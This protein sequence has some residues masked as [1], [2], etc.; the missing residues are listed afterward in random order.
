MKKP[1][2]AESFLE[3]DLEE[4]P[5]VRSNAIQALI[6]INSIVFNFVGDISF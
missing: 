6:S 1:L 3:T 5:L 4:R 2:I